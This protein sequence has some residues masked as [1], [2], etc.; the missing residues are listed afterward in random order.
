L[1]PAP[2]EPSETGDFNG[3]GMSAILW[4]DGTGNVA[5]WFMTGANIASTIGLGNVGTSWTVQ[6]HNAE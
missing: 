1:V 6:A 3:N 2:P 4:I 5:I